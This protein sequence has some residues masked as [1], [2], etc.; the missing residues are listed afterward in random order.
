[1]SRRIE[2]V[3]Y[4]EINAAREKMREVW[5]EDL[6]PWY[7][8]YSGGKDSTLLLQLVFEVAKEEGRKKPKKIWVCF[9]D[10]GYELDG[11]I[12]KIKR[13][14]EL[15]E[16]TGLVQTMF[17]HP[18]LDHKI[19]VSII[20]RGY[21]P[22]DFRFRYCTQD[23]KMSPG[24]CVETELAKAHNGLV[25]LVGQR[26]E[27][28]TNRCRNLNKKFAPYY[29]FCR[30]SRLKIEEFYPIANI[31]ERDLWK[32]LEC[33]DTFA[34]NGSFKEL[35]ESYS[36]ARG[37]TRD[38]CWLCTVCVEKKARTNQCTDGQNK[39]RQFLREIKDDP[40]KRC[41]CTKENFKKRIEKGLA[42]GYFTLEA[43]KEMLEFVQNIEREEGRRYISDE[44]V[45]IIH[46]F[47]ESS[48]SLKYL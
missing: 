2:A 14:F 15:F 37:I 42:S 33:I 41:L 48:K 46:N 32:Y 27:E 6:R 45:D 12:E 10:T 18:E 26:K 20:G 13:H 35:R 28:S 9:N 47:W 25:V 1:M 30:N 40:Q 34:W 22:P 43:R 24:K 19:L 38:G 23:S 3:C 4:A 7:V 29:L 44:E 39:I 36:L 17:T 31:L 16:K 11:K 21:A 5:R 8:A